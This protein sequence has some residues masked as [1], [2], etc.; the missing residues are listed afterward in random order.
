[1]LVP[2]GAVQTTLSPPHPTLMWVGLL[3]YSSLGAVA[4]TTWMYLPLG[5]DQLGPARTA[6]YSYLQPF[7]AVLAA[8]L[9]IGEPV[10]PLQVLGGAIGR[11]RA[12]PTPA[13]A[14]ISAPGAGP[15]GRTS[16]PPAR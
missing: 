10:L 2:L 4:L 16:Q 12:R 14:P 13:R 7:L 1:M 3:A 8:G 11:P 5:S 15:Q 9:L 6:V